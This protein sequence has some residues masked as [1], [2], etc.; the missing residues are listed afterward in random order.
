[1]SEISEL[2]AE[3]GLS[4]E[5]I[6]ESSTLVT[7][8]DR[9]SAMVKQHSAADEK[10]D[11]VLKQTVDLLNKD[12]KLVAIIEEFRV[13]QLTEAQSIIDADPRAAILLVD[14]FQANKQA[15]MY[16]RDYVLTKN[17]AP[18]AKKAKVVNEEVQE[19]F[20]LARQLKRGIEIAFEV[21]DRPQ[22][23]CVC[24]WTSG[25][26][27]KRD[28][29]EREFAKHVKSGVEGESHVIGFPTKA[30]ADKKKKNV[31]PELPRLKGDKEDKDG[32][33]KAVG[34][35]AANKKLRFSVNG[36]NLPSDTSTNDLAYKYVSDREKGANVTWTTITAAIKASGQT[37]LSNEGWT[38][39]VNGKTV[40]GWKVDDE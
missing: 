38:V 27:A 31:L 33:S 10:K 8:F 32:A 30:S 16:E 2:F 28:V 34:R 24:G 26:E 6:A 4:I 17:V 20:N 14:M 23:V 22:Q 12:K 21:Q 7:L 13:R 11:S 5:A 36:E 25:S 39:V 3:L 29:A 37:T 40:K 19:K 35:G 18:I 9:Y 15:A 1:M